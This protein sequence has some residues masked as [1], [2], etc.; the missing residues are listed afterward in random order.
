MAVVVGGDKEREGVMIDKIFK[1]NFGN[2]RTHDSRL[3]NFSNTPLYN[4]Y[5][6]KFVYTGIHAAFTMHEN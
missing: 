6:M 1:L 2:F 3:A 5:G 4:V